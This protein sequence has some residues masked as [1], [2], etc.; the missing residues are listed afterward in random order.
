ML[1]QRYARFCAGITLAILLTVLATVTAC[2][3]RPFTRTAPSPEHLAV[4]Q[5]VPAERPFTQPPPLPERLGFRQINIE[6]GLPHY[7]V[8][9]IAQDH[10]GFIW[11]GTLDGLVRYDGNRFDVYRPDPSNPNAPSSGII[12]ELYADRDGVI[13]AGTLG[14]GLTR[15]DPR[16]EQFTRY[17]H[18]PADPESLSSDAIRAIYKDAAG[19]L[20]IG[21]L[22][23][24]L[25]RLDPQ[26][27]RFTHYRHDPDD[28]AGLSSDHVEAIVEDG[29]GGLWIATYG[30]LDRLD[31]QSGRF[32]HYRHE[33]GNPL[34]LGGNRV[35]ALCLDRAG[36]LWVGV[37]GVGLYRLDPAL[38]RFVSYRYDPDDPTSL[39]SN[40]I[41]AIYE[42]S[43]GG[44]WVATYDGLNRLNPDGTSFTR[45]HR[46][47][48]P[49]AGLASNN[50]LTVTESRDGLLW[51]GSQDYGVTIIDSDP[52]GF[53]IYRADS[54]FP[55][56]LSTGGIRAI[57]EDRDGTLWV[58]LFGAG[59]DRFD[60]TSGRAMHYR[61]DPNDPASLSHN[62]VVALLIDQDGVLW[63][64][65]NDG[66]NRFNRD[67]GDFTR[68]RH[69]LDD[70]TS[71]SHNDVYALL[72]D[73][74]GVLWIATRGGGLCRFNRDRGDFTHYRHD[75]NDPAS[76]GSDSLLTLLED[77]SGAL[78]IGT[79]DNGL[80][81]FESA[82]GSFTHYR[83][84]LDDPT[85][86]G[87]HTV[88]T[89]FEDADGTL[90]AGVWN[91]GLDRFDPASDSF[92]H[93]RIRDGLLSDKINSIQ[94]D[95]AGNLWLGSNQGLSKLDPRT[96]VISSFTN[97]SAGLPHGG[98]S[99][100]SSAQSSR[101]ELLLG[102][103]NSLVT[104]FPAQIQP[105]SDVPPVVFTSFLL[106]NR[107][108]V[109]GGDS[110]LQAS[111]NATDTLALSYR[112]RMIG[113]EFA[114]LDYRAPQ[115]VR[116][117]YMLE[118]FDSDWIEVDSQQRVATY[119]NL[120][121]GSYSF[122][123]KAANGDEVWGSNVRSIRF[124]IVP[125]WWETWW[126]RTLVALAIAIGILGTVRLRLYRLQAQ[127]RQLESEVAA[128]TRELTAANEKLAVEVAERTRAEEAAR[129]SRD[130]FQRQLQIE[131]DLI[132]APDLTPL[133][134]RILVQLSAVIEYITAL[135]ITVEGE[136]GV[137]RAA[138]SNYLRI[139][140]D[141]LQLDLNQLPEVRAL[142]TRRTPLMV[143]DLRQDDAMAQYLDV[144]FGQR[145]KGR[146]LIAVPLMVKGQSIGVLGIT[147]TTPG[148]YTEDDIKHLEIFASP[149][150]I[151]LENARLR[152]SAEHAAVIEERNRLARE[153]HDAVTQTL[154]SASLIAEA[155][156]DIWQRS[157]AMAAQGVTDLRRLTAGA[158]A[159]MRTLLLEL[160]PT[161]LTEKPLGQLLQ[162][163][164]T[165]MSNR[166]AIAMKLEVDRDCILA[167][168]VQVAF[169]R[170]AQ[171]A[172]NN[173]SKHAAAQQVV[174]RFD[175]APDEAT[176][177]VTDDGQGFAVDD[178]RPDSLGFGIMRERAAEI[179][180][181]L[182]ITSQPGAGTDILLHWHAPA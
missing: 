48:P 149:V 165:A 9:G 100:N 1:S 50:I 176:L 129:V 34:G 105:R 93:Y 5:A 156:P 175:C 117:R 63:V 101:G 19:T 58:G 55:D 87:A 39:S 113:F 110:P 15:Y 142:L 116:Y 155:L 23:G 2:A 30:G 141:S 146:N 66:L 60:R 21:T 68:Y 109:V 166:T 131:N 119:T 106:A 162:L 86:I 14:A 88:A 45:L 85:S 95:A 148:Y 160:R 13:W 135:I 179:E 169:Y 81:R 178:V 120:N 92:T 49:F 177:R 140:P 91:S 99:L 90:W 27:G 97:A 111:L 174:I 115:A 180:A 10:Y 11:L 67:R 51:V 126:F 62:Q 22:D 138:R 6:H 154:F 123:V 136:K 144:A 18:N 168:P 69:D 171:E 20:W 122:H 17:R 32:T 38:G 31:P 83:H 134:N 132:T 147:H 107:P 59:L 158:L 125:P 79:E 54:A 173:V 121:P 52:N 139:A 71:L 42:D 47:Q 104:F 170:I 167:G 61:H 43:S 145:I 130:E 25:N 161:A 28:P 151:A 80:D 118:G 172:L 103:A 53:N 102:A 112:D 164:C 65:T 153:L 77:R 157:P 108:V 36:A 12:W 16:T 33:P 41:N 98:F 70:P 133:L 114:A 182:T 94:E 84:D 76:I 152:E 29:H 56:G 78:W 96:S 44:L 75:P 35:H 128:R 137:V 40:D 74:A 24:G 72:E 159:E 46:A 3:E 124:I 73:R 163:L 127:Q 37:Y 8:F 181:T 26:T 4:S 143:A 150:A 82:T 57:A 89:L 7:G 64:G